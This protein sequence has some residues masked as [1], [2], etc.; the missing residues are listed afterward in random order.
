MTI[1]ACPKC[2]DLVALPDRASRRATVRCPLCQEQ[3]LLREVLDKLPPALMVVDDPE[4][5]DAAPAGEAAPEEW[6]RPAFPD[7]EGA[8]FAPLSIET[9]AARAP[10][11]GVPRGR[12]PAPRAKR[13]PKNPVMEG[14]KIV[15]G[16]V[17]GLAIA[18]IILW[19]VGS[20]QAWPKQRADMFEL[21]PKVARFAPWIVPDRYRGAP[22]TGDA[23]GASED[24][25]GAVAMGSSNDS[26][27]Q[28]LPQRTFVDPNADSRADEAAKTEPAKAKKPGRSTTKK[29]PQ[30]AGM[31]D[32]L[33]NGPGG[34]GASEK[35]DVDLGQ[36]PES[37]DDPLAD[38]DLD[39]DLE[40]T[41]DRPVADP[42]VTPVM[43]PESEPAVEPKPAAEPLPNAPRT[44]A[45]E[46][47]TAVEEAQT[48]VEALKAAPEADVRPLLR[49]AYVALA[50]VGETAAFRSPSDTAE[51]QSA[52]DL[53]KTLIA[54][55]ARLDT[56]SKAAGVW[57]KTSTRDNN[58]VLLVG[59]VKEVRQQGGY[60]VTELVIPGR[61][62]TVAVYRGGE[63]GDAY[64]SDTRLVVLGAIITSPGKDLVGY[65]G[66]GDPVVWE[67][68]AEPLATP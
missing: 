9:E 35:L 3:F 28:G 14:V 49:Q 18:Q 52:D 4:V 39:L 58:G 64:P 61:D 30:A 13:K 27:P 57:L 47:R 40:T 31:D 67:G 54:E 62:G 7:A 25:A 8:G 5:A 60:R 19:W 66:D 43:E 56:L 26:Q 42:E 22:S 41:G 34:I 51:L 55:E 12:R 15:L 1:V 20:S 6:V 50:K 65:E 33:A 24:D 21:A 63:D 23:V 29:T 11:T 59:T 17:A 10:A 36:V 53:L 68:L 48:V 45:A 2:A 46:L 16:G 37:N 38:M 44:T 32:G